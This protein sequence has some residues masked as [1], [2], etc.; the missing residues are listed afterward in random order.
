MKTLLITFYLSKVRS[1][2]KVTFCSSDF[3]PRAVQSAV[4]TPAAKTNDVRLPTEHGENERR[5]EF[6]FTPREQFPFKSAALDTTPQEAF[7]MIILIFP[8]WGISRPLC[9]LT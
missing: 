1:S 8:D 2:E 4:A 3:S 6:G 7:L 9:K 5:Q